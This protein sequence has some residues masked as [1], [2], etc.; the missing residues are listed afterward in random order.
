MP[1][2][3]I[4]FWR[5]C[6]AVMRFHSLS[7]AF[8][9]K[10]SIGGG[11]IPRPGEISRAHGGV[12]FLDELP[13]F[14][15]R[16]LDVLREPL[17]SGVIHISRA[18]RQA[19]FPA[20][21]QLV[22]AMNPCPCGF[23]GDPE[24]ACRCTPDQVARYRGR[25]SGPF[26][27]RIDLHVTVPRLKPSELRRMNPG[28]ESAAVRE[29]VTAAWQRQQARQG[30]C[31]AALGGREL[32]SVWP[33]DPGVE[34]LLEQASSRFRLSA[35]S[36]HRIWRVTATIADLAGADAISAANMAEALAYRPGG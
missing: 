22:A 8:T 3:R 24:H 21:F 36:H 25:V 26:L 34:A 20:S 14:D 32:E 16:V 23:R 12:L 10:K 18:A 6:N 27:D 30:K 29:R 35:R 33:L 19:E 4:L 2:L 13:E 7:F 17:E 1:T 15:R 9:S 31:N 11:S 5:Y 28:E